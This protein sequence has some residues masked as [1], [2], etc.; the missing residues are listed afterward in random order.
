[1]A[2]ASCELHEEWIETQTYF[3]KRKIDELEKLKNIAT[4]NEKECF[5]AFQRACDNIKNAKINLRGVF[6]E[7][8]NDYN[9]LL[10]KYNLILEELDQIR[11][12]LSERKCTEKELK[13]IAETIDR[14]KWIWIDQSKIKVELCKEDV[15]IYFC[16]GK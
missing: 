7:R 3:V 13:E 10:K 4:Q 12:A 16:H 15:Q 8:T 5:E 2:M 9:K 6:Q 14:I 1:M 11:N